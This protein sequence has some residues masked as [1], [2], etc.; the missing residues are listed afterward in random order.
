MLIEVLLAFALEIGFESL[1]V[2][3]LEVEG[4]GHVKVVEEPCDVEKY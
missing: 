1:A 3:L 4:C 2:V